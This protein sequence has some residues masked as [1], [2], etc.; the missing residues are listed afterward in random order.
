[1]LILQGRLVLERLML[2]KKNKT[3]SIV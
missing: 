2:S 3:A 1:M